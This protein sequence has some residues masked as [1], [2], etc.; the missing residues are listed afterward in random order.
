LRNSP[1]RRPEPL[2]CVPKPLPSFARMKDPHD[3]NRAGLCLALHD[4]H[5]IDMTASKLRSRMLSREFG[6]VTDPFTSTTMHEVCL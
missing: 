1:T 4:L 3:G 2:G 6:I 5:A